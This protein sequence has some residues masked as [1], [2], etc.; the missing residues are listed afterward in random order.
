MVP[1]VASAA[2]TFEAFR[3]P[4]APKLE[5]S[6]SL[7]FFAWGVDG[8]DMA[9]VARKVAG[10]DFYSRSFDSD[11][12]SALEQPLADPPSGWLH[13]VVNAVLGELPNGSVSALRRAT[14]EPRPQRSPTTTTWS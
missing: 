7:Q 9:S 12:G 8:H 11:A 13:V 6:E 10:W 1:P 5:G 2:M 4:Y 3:V 14:R